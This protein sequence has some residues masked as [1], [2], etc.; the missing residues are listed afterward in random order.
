MAAAAPKWDELQRLLVHLMVST[1]APNKNWRD[2]ANLD[3]RTYVAYVRY[4]KGVLPGIDGVV[5]D[6]GSGRGTT[7]AT[8]RQHLLPR[9]VYGVDP[10]PKSYEPAGPDPVVAPAYDTVAHLRQA[11]PD[12]VALLSLVWPLP[13][14]STFDM[15]AVEVCRPALVV[16][17]VD[18]SGGAGGTRLQHW[19]RRAA[20]HPAPPDPDEAKDMPRYH[21]VCSHG[22]PEG[23][24]AN[25]ILLLRRDDVHLPADVPLPAHD[26]ACLRRSAMALDPCAYRP[27]QAALTKCACAPSVK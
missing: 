21:V 25:T 2:P 18:L 24:Y 3:Y 12:D 13:N 17:V 16:T 5:V 27:G 4:L 22:H 10:D 11:V 19:L 7:T 15:D 23:E 14:D 1:T 8:L 6:V 26:C 9:R 20:G